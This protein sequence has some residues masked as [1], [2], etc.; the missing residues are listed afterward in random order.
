[1]SDCR[2]FLVDTYDQCQ[3][4]QTGARKATRSLIEV[5]NYDHMVLVNQKNSAFR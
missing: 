5:P 3:Y 1:M 4:A 2:R